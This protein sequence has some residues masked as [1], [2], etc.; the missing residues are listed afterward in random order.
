MTSIFTKPQPD[1]NWSMIIEAQ[2]SLLAGGCEVSGSRFQAKK[3]LDLRQSASNSTEER[4]LPLLR[5]ACFAKTTC[6]CGRVACFDDT[7]L[8]FGNSYRR[9]GRGSGGASLAQKAQRYGNVRAVQIKVE[10]PR[11]ENLLRQTLPLLRRACFAKTT[12]AGR[13]LHLRPA[14]LSPASTNSYRCFGDVVAEV[15]EARWSLARPKVS[16]AKFRSMGQLH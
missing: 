3:L 6:T 9:S 14:V 16:F 12:F 7:Y 10:C 2:R 4:P 1:S 5:R 13:A 11:H 8:C 15:G